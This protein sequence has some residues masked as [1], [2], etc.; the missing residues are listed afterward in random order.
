M[1]VLVICVF[2]AFMM[3]VVSRVMF[4]C[5]FA[6]DMCA[7]VC[8]VGVLISVCLK[9]QECGVDVVCVCLVLCVC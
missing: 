4:V 1:C 8:V 3:C 2:V 9:V 5:V 6:C 7:W